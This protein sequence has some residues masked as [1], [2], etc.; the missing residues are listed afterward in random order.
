MSPLQGLRSEL[1]E[2]TRMIFDAC[3]S[4]TTKDKADLI[5]LGCVHPT[6]TRVHGTWV[7]S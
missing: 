4:R 1:Q 7:L 6:S 5:C 3:S 2:Y